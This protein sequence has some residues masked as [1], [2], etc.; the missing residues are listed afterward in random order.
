MS[1]SPII[2]TPEFNLALYPPLL[3]RAA[4][5]TIGD[6]SMYLLSVC[7]PKRP[8]ILLQSLAM[9]ELGIDQMRKKDVSFWPI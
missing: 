1:I 5:I 7:V 9:I 4:W 2:S 3:D 6:P 8:P